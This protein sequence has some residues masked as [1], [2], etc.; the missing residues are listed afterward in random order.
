MNALMPSTQ[1]SNIIVP[2]TVN[3]QGNTNPTTTTTTTTTVSATLC[4]SDGNA[5]NSSDDDS[6]SSSS[7][8]NEKTPY[9]Q[10]LMALY[11]A[12]I[13]QLEQ[14]I[15]AMKDQEQSKNIPVLLESSTNAS[16]CLESN[17]EVY[18]REQLASQLQK[19][20]SLQESITQRQQQCQQTDQVWNL[21]TLFV[22]AL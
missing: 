17:Q 5:S 8:L 2:V 16:S 21:H 13:N 3:Q 15:Q 22:H 18:L 12:K 7:L 11:Q 9:H 6:D 19:T 1:S 4:L 14:T 20:A 10:Q